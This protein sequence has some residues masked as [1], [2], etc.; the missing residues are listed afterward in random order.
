LLKQQK[1]LLATSIDFASRHIFIW[2]IYPVVTI[3]TLLVFL[4]RETAGIRICV[5]GVPLSIAA[6]WLVRNSYSAI[7]SYRQLC[8]RGSAA[9]SC[10]FHHSVTLKLFAPPVTFADSECGWQTTPCGAAESH[11]R[12]PKNRKHR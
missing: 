7:T 1:D 2:G 5:V 3:G 10:A 4:Q 9:A 6:F 8:A 11:Q 12:T